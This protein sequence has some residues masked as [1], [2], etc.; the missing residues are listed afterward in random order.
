MAKGPCPVLEWP[1]KEPEGGGSAVPTGTSLLL[2]W[3]QGGTQHPRS[4]A[5]LGA[6]VDQESCGAVSPTVMSPGLS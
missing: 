3:E 4:R 2:L 5:G 1:L 6:E